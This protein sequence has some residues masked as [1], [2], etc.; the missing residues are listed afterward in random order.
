MKRTMQT[1]A[2]LG[3]AAL[4]C[5]V[6][7]A[8]D[9]NGTL[10]DQEGTT[11]DGYDGVDGSLDS[12]SHDSTQNWVYQ[13]GSGSWTGIYRKDGW[14][15]ET[16]TGDSTIDIE[17]DIEMFYTETFENNKIY[18]HIG[19]PTTATEAD[20][21]ALVT[22]SFTSNNGQYIGISFDGTA[23][24]ADD[25]LKDGGG[26]YTGEVQNAMVL[27]KDVLGRVPGP[28]SIAPAAFNAR[29]SLSWDNGM[30]FH[31]PVTFGTGASGTILNTLWWLVDGGGK[32][33]YNLQYKVELLFDAV[34]DD[35][36][37]G[38]DPAIVAAPVL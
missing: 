21:T 15:G 24:T 14:T 25:M 26:D 9:L 12:S 19:N 31:P 5:S 28:G 7:S 16:S 22:G 18:F 13:Y 1:L 20:K 3:L 33:S 23:K 11:A 2:L 8:Q 10:W 34:Q 27:K 30:N 17:C 32:G 38:F 37:Y 29:F 6:A 4:L 35:G 36:T